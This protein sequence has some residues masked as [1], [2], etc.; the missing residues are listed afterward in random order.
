MRLPRIAAA[1]AAAASFLIFTPAASADPDPLYCVAVQR[2]N[3]LHIVVRPFEWCV[4]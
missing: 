1:L 2:Q 3:V 4:L